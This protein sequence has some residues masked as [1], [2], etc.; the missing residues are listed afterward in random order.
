MCQKDC[1]PIQA[2]TRYFSKIKCYP[3]LAGFKKKQLFSVRTVN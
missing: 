3:I 2:E 1:A